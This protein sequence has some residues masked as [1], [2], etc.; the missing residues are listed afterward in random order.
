MTR[1]P[2][3]SERRAQDGGG[4][5]PPPCGKFRHTSRKAARLAERKLRAR[6]GRQDTFPCRLTPGIWHLGH[7]P[8]AIK[9]GL[10]SRDIYRRRRAT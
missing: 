3:V 8:K 7:L 5:C 9:R 10:I 1:M 4:Y 6:H 2:K